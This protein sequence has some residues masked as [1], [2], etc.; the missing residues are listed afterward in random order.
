MDNL[1]DCVEDKGVHSRGLCRMGRRDL[2]YFG[3]LW[4]L[5]ILRELEC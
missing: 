2:V 5:K 4:V 3:L 1:K